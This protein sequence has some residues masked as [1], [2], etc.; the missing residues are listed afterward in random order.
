MTGGRLVRSYMPGMRPPAPRR[1]FRTHWDDMC[2]GTFAQA[3]CMFTG[4][5]RPVSCL[6]SHS[7]LSQHCAGVRTWG[8]SDPARYLRQAQALEGLRCQRLLCRA[9]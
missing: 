9:W 7:R 2:R 3:F 6:D 4:G 8:L 5:A 1:T